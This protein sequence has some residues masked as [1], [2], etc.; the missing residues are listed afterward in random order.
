MYFHVFDFCTNGCC[1]DVDAVISTVEGVR[2]DQ[3][4]LRLAMSY[5]M[6]HFL[7]PLSLITNFLTLSTIL[8][9]NDVQT[10]IINYTEYLF[11]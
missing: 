8:A 3:F 5:P 2:W 6:I 4:P 10:I 1:G 7:C 9:S 11:F